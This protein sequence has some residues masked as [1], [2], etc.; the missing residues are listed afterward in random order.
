MINNVLFRWW[1]AMKSG[2]YNP[3]DRIAAE[4]C[5]SSLVVLI[6]ESPKFVELAI[7]SNCSSSAQYSSVV[8]HDVGFAFVVASPSFFIG[9]DE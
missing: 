8:S 5:V 3:V 9:V 2:S 1:F 6:A 7:A 4:K